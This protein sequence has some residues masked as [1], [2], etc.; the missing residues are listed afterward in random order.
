TDLSLITSPSGITISDPPGGS[1]SSVS[2][3]QTPT[4][5][6]FTISAGSANT[7]TY[8]AQAGGTSSTEKTIVFEDPSVLT[9]EGSPSSVSKDVNKSFILSIDVSNSQE[10]AITTSYSL[11]YSSSDF[12]VSGDP[13]SDSNVTINADST[14]NLQ[15]NITLDSGITTGTYYITLELG[16][17]DEAFTVTVSATGATTTTTST[18][19][20]TTD[21]GGGGG[22]GTT[23]EKHRETKIWSIITPGG[24][25]I[26][27]ITDKEIGF[28]QI[29][30]SVKNQANNVRITVTKLA[31]QPASVVHEVS[32]KVY[33]YMEINTENLD[34]D[35]VDSAKLRFEVAKEWISENNIDPYTVVLNRYQNGWTRLRTRLISQDSNSY[36]YEADSPGFS[37]FAVTGE[38]LAR[39]E[40]PESVEVPE[41]GEEVT[42]GK[43]PSTPLQ[44]L[45]T[46][47]QTQLYV[48][49]V[50]FAIFVG[51][52]A[53]WKRH[54]IF[55]PGEKPPKKMP[56][57]L[58]RWIEENLKKGYKPEELRESMRKAG[59]N[60]KYV[61]ILLKSRKLNKKK[62]QYK[63]KPS[64]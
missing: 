16:D 49:L 3:S 33:R 15:W 64:K 53:Y 12:S 50:L 19:T 39:A 57:N 60:P 32:G 38:V 40:E 18:T 1:Y 54:E 48:S 27:K 14:K 31:G 20:T 6:T 2:V 47:T 7:Y 62:P 22:G 46:G 34:D 61:D 43:I 45:P 8:Y 21:G 44:D 35:N 56:G 23:P 11:D 17:N 25:E 29:Q 59:R 24:V 63:Y 42:E 28:K 52:I 55:G 26:M 13:T 51:A 36:T 9:V 58:E 41:G 5:K 37:V 4:T 10:D 30:V